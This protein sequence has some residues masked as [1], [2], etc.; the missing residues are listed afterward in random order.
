MKFEETFAPSGFLPSVA[1]EFNQVESSLSVSPRHS[2]LSPLLPSNPL[3]F[4]TLLAFRLSIPL[5]YRPIPPA[6]P[7][8]CSFDT[9]NSIPP[10]YCAVSFLPFCLLVRVSTPWPV[11][12]INGTDRYSE[13]TYNHTRIRVDDDSTVLNSVKLLEIASI[14][15]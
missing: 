2:Q 15:F 8:P 12:R 11:K 5:V 4:P 13:H 3:P 9:P 7:H 1:S 10:A 6:A 14:R